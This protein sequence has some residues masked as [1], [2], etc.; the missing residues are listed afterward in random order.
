MRISSLY[1]LRP[2]HGGQIIDRAVRLYRNNFWPCIF[3]TLLVEIPLLFSRLIWRPPFFDFLTTPDSWRQ[4]AYVLLRFLLV[5]GVRLLTVAALSQVV[6][7]GYE[8]EKVSVAAAYRRVLSHWWEILL[9]TLT[10]IPM[11]VL[12]VAWYFIPCIGSLS[13]VGLNAFYFTVLVPLSVPIVML[14]GKKG[15]AVLRRAWE[16]TRT[17][18]W[19]TIGFV[20]FALVFFVSVWAGPRLFVQLTLISVLQLNNQL[21]AE[22]ALPGLSGY[23]VV[24][25]VINTIFI[26]LIWPILMLTLHVWYLDLRV[27]REGLDLFLW[28]DQ[29][30]PVALRS[31]PEK[32]L[33]LAP[34]NASRTWLSSAELARFMGLTILTVGLPIALFYGLFILSELLN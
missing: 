14:E 17:R 19:P 5:M 21:Y 6:V 30:M 11:T 29:Q 1:L 18:F 22:F 32:V 24:S 10:L 13:G 9:T 31:G 34:A 20:L 12:I 27:R 15:P 3:I 28:A 4:L 26:T 33:T 7:L 23:L 25:D 8:G 16:L 2:L